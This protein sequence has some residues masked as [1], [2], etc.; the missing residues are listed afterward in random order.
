MEEILD[1]SSTLLISTKKRQPP[2][3]FLENYDVELDN[4]EQYSKYTFYHYAPNG[5]DEQQLWNRHIDRVPIP[6][7]LE[8]LLQLKLD[9]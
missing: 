7:D 9:L 3:I 1:R 2:E 6:I 8:H 5:L 4:V